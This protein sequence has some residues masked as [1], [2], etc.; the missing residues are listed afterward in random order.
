MA[1][2]DR[3]D[4]IAMITIVAI[5][6]IVTVIWGERIGVHGGEGWDGQSYVAWGTDLPHAIAHDLNVLQAQRVLP[7]ALVYY[8]LSALGAAHTSA[9]VIAGFQV[10]DSVCLVAC[11]FFLARIATAL[12]WSRPAAWGAFAATFLGFAVARHA[13]Y[14]P[15]LTDPLAF[16]LSMAMVWAFVT[17]RPIALWFAMLAIAFTWPAALPL[18]FGM[19][20]FPRATDE[21]PVTAGRRHRI[22]AIAAAAVVAVAIAVVFIDVLHEPEPQ[23][24]RWVERS[25]RALW[26]PTIALTIATSALATYWLVR[27]DRALAIRAYLAQ[28]GW[29]RL[30]LGA[31][32]GLAIVALRTY[33]VHRV[34]VPGA[35]FGLRELEFYS[36]AVAIRGPL[37]NVV[38]H[39]VY[40]GPIVLFAIGAWS[41][42]AA[43][44]AAWGPAAVLALG[45]LVV[46]GVSP[47][48]RHIQH[49]IPF[50]I[51]C[52]VTA[53][54]DWWTPR[55]T[56]AFV[57]LALAWS[58]VWLR[59]GYDAPHDS[60]A[61]PDLRYFMQQAAW[62]SDTTFLAHLVAAAVSALIL[63]GAAKYGSRASDNVD[64]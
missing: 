14:Y 9:N 15:A 42:L 47:D 30:A 18:A 55:R 1:R 58:K 22:I 52:A 37:W 5:G 41:R 35:P 29:K 19:L 63:Y 39:V 40:F 59:I 25:H 44:A 32:G 54:R 48:A 45:A 7:S 23:I 24:E 64:G 6:A 34:A 21:L 13:L 38:H 10:L 36:A 49:Y 62:A 8:A 46:F 27:A 50:L 20:V 53:T 12:A 57:A 28:I 56:L 26:I 51:V 17:R 16:A 2:F 61:W 31:A 60:Y 3:R 4:A 33:W 43:A 11:A